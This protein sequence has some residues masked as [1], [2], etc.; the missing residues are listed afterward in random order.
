MKNKIP[1]FYDDTIFGIQQVGGVSIVFNLLI[2][3]FNTNP[4]FEI[5]LIENYKTH[6][7]YYN[8]KIKKSSVHITILRSILQFLPI[9]KFLPANSIFHSTYYRYSFQKNIKRVLTIHDLTY[10]NGFI[11]NKFKKAFH[12]FFKRISIANSDY[13]ICISKSTYHD[14]E[15]YY[16]RYLQGKKIFIIHNSISDDFFKYNPINIQRISNKLLYVGSRAGYKNFD[17]LIIALKFLENYELH[18]VGGPD[19]SIEELSF[20]NK[21]LEGRYFFYNNLTTNEIIYHYYSSFCLI[22]PSSYEGFG[23]PLVEAMICECPIITTKFS[24]IPEIVS[25]HAFFLEEITTKNIIDLI[26]YINI[27]TIEVKTKIIIAKQ[28]AHLY[29]LQNQINKYI[30]TYENIFNQ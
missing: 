26:N 24:C 15:K 6:N 25:D 29:T 14:F 23:L 27:N 1:L 16:S 21:N 18:I 9:F 10:E 13:F 22:Y 30:E 4:N 11:N 8:F 5:Q 20:L 12:L 19:M 2:N 7:L 28:R 17:K 3:Y